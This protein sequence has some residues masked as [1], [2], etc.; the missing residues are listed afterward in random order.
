[1]AKL[2]IE[3]LAARA[4]SAA[5]VVTL[6]LASL[7]G[8]ADTL[9]ATAG[10]G[11]V[12]SLLTLPLLA[13]TK[14]RAVSLLTLAM[15]G[16]LAF[17]GLSG[18][19]GNWF[20]ARA[21]VIAL[22]TAG[23]V[24]VAGRAIG[25]TDQLLN[26]T[27]RVLIWGMLAFCVI[28]FA[29]YLIDISSRA[30][31]SDFR[32]KHAFGSANT[33]ATLFGLIALIGT[34][35]SIYAFRHTQSSSIP[36]A[37]RMNAVIRRNLDSII[38]SVVALSCLLLTASRAGILIGFAMVFIFIA[39]E[40]SEHLRLKG[41]RRKR[42][43]LIV[44]L[45]PLVLGAVLVIGALSTDIMFARSS[46]IAGDAQGRIDL[47]KTYWSMWVSEPMVGHGLGS[48]N[49]LN[50]AN[51]TLENAA[52]TGNMGA[53]HNVI[54]QWLMQQGLLG[55]TVLAGVL[56]AIHVRLFRALTGTRQRSGTF[57]RVAIC[58]SGL[59]LLHGMVDYAM[60]IP[61]VMWT[62]AFILGMATGRAGVVSRISR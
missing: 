50:D 13:L 30:Q 61:S 9:T 51:V 2:P 56:T 35:Y 58:A 3:T 27:W 10:F 53:A 45:M 52:L 23:V 48:F 28:V 20:Q 8:G 6:L 12:M 41:K 43:H 60:E 47:Y 59:V 16:F 55:F 32:M 57:L 18:N 25:S 31:A 49:R 14:F 5:L 62:Y 26:W 17:W 39:A 19:F 54:L 38:L 11:L 44:T 29:A 15:V 34:G 4:L 46:D 1:M 7:R 42:R 21:E 40:A 24:F 33:A 36:R 37:H 22:A